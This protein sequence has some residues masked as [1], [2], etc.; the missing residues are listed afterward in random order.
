MKSVT[1]TEQFASILDKI[2][3]NYALS[4]SLYSYLYYIYVNNLRDEFLGFLTVTDK[5]L[6][7]LQGKTCLLDLPSERNYQTSHHSNFVLN[8]IFYVNLKVFDPQGNHDL[9]SKI[10]DFLVHESKKLQ[11]EDKTVGFELIVFGFQDYLNILDFTDLYEIYLNNISNRLAIKKLTSL[12]TPEGFKGWWS[13]V[14]LFVNSI[15]LSYYFNSSV[16]CLNSPEL[17]I[18]LSS[19]VKIF[20]KELEEFVGSKS[21]PP[22]FKAEY[23]EL[24]WIGD[25]LSSVGMLEDDQQE[26]GKK[27]YNKYKEINKIG[28]YKFDQQKGF[29]ISPNFVL[30]DLDTTAM[31]LKFLKQ[32]DKDPKLNSMDYYLEKDSIKTYKNDNRESI[33][34]I[35]HFLSYS[36]QLKLDYSEALL[37]KMLC[38][39]DAWEISDKFHSSESY[40]TYTILC[41]LIDVQLAGIQDVENYI[42]KVVVKICEDIDLQNENPLKSNLTFEELGWSIVGLSYLQN[43]IPNLARNVKLRDYIK[44]AISYKKDYI[45]L[46]ILKTT[47]SCRNINDT[48]ELAIRYLYEKNS[49]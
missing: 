32:I 46:W 43:R 12:Y 3:T 19:R 36:A 17:T 35:A 47:Y 33:T 4:G 40:V 27:L 22:Y 20:R 38:R 44:F 8:L 6:L 13:K 7:T 45:P 11:V 2:G 18:F 48:L 21:F 5:H 39:V 25:I 1:F 9:K 37:A 42:L 15:L 16:L 31:G 26:M 14:K 24:F 41:A 29:P 28:P 49:L 30:Y 10:Y 34:A 23:F